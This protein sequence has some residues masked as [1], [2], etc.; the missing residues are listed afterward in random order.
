MKWT[1]QN[2]GAP[3]WTLDVAPEYFVKERAPG[4]FVAC[5]AQHILADRPTADDARCLAE[6]AY[7][8][9]DAR[10]ER[11][12]VFLRMYGGIEGDHHRRWVIAQ[13]QVILPGSEP[14]MEHAVTESSSWLSGTDSWPLRVLAAGRRPAWPRAGPTPRKIPP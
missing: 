5:V 12:Q 7:L 3:C 4:S 6:S 1:E 8:S 9:P 2:G 10:C 13:T 14:D 11:A